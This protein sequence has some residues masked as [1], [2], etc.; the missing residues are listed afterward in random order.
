MQHTLQAP[1]DRVEQ[2]RAACVGVVGRLAPWKGQHIFLHAAVLVRQGFP[3]T[4][5]QIIGGALFDEQAYEAEL[6]AL[7]RTLQLEENSV[8]VFI[9]IL[10][11]GLAVNIQRPGDHHG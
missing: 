4:V 10:L 5:F 8:A 3:G 9:V 6:K 7:V 1:A 11:P 2:G